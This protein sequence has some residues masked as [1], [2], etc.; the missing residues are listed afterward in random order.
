MVSG[1]STLLNVVSDTLEEEVVA[2]IASERREQRERL[3]PRTT[4]FGDLG[5]D[6][7]DAEELF[8]AFMKRFE[9]DMSECRAKEHFGPEGFVPWAPIYWMILAWRGVTEEGSTPE[10]RARLRPVTIQDLI[11]SAR[12][13]KWAVTYDRKV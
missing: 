1:L 11:D 13:R 8:D 6:G 10:S 9:V 3:S 5:V 2:F 7:D 4:L 12:A